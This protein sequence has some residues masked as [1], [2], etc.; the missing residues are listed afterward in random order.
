MNMGQKASAKNITRS[1]PLSDGI[2]STGTRRT[3]GP[4]SENQF[5]DLDGVWMDDQMPN[6]AEAKTM[7]PLQRRFN[8][9]VGGIIIAN[10]FVIAIE[11]D[12]G[13]DSPKGSKDMKPF[14]VFVD[15]MFILAFMIEIFVRV[16]WERWAWPRSGWNWFDLLIVVLAIVDIWIL[17]F[18]SD[19]SRSLQVMSVFR[20]VRLFRLIRLVK[21]VRLL[22]GLY[23]ILLAMWHAM[24]TMSFLLAIMAFG[25]LIYSIFAVNLIGRNPALSGIR[26]AGTDTVYDRFGTL[27]RAM[28]SLFEL[29]TLE[30]WESV[31]RPIVEE[32][33]WLFI[34]IVSYIMIFTFGMLNMIVATVIEK[35]LY[36][37]RVMSD[38]QMAEERQRMQQELLH[39]RSVF[40]EGGKERSGKMTFEEFEAAMKA[41]PPIREIFD[42]MGISILDARELYS[43]L[44]WD[45]SGDLTIKEFLSGI[46]KLQNGVC[47]PWDA[48]ATHAIV[49]NNRNKIAELHADFAHFDEESSQWHTQMQKRFGEQKEVM[50]DILGRLETSPARRSLT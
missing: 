2:G 21:L 22:Q 36:Y 14:W 43:V 20:I 10:V 5:L 44:D 41:H 30:G 25:L 45:E 33:P 6:E 13:Y 17:G 37:T 29:M 23:I 39:I 26:I 48:L 32:E 4:V 11:T 38:T 42:N 28:Y 24:Q 27:F 49:R 7:T 47:S 46:N 50:K 18:L 34:F 1:D 12:Y 15:S 8:M 3:T 9:F 31:A 40:D 19:N 16:H 35:T